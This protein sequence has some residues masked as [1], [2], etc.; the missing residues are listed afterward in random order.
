L[1]ALLASAVV[2][3]PT[4]GAEPGDAKDSTGIAALLK[5]WEDGITKKN[6]DLLFS[7]LSEEIVYVEPA[8]RTEGMS[9]PRGLCGQLH[10]GSPSER[11]ARVPFAWRERRCQ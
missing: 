11:Y 10:I 3:A 1:T 8:H 6:T 4:R 9:V 7:S 2:T 5:R